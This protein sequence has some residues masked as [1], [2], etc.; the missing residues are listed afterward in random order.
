MQYIE[1]IEFIE[2]GR[3]RDGYRG[4]GKLPVVDRSD[5]S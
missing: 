5:R 4:K 1:F 2:F 3:V